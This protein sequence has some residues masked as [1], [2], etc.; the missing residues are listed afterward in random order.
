MTRVTLLCG[1][2]WFALAAGLP[3]QNADFDTLFARLK[4]GP[5]YQTQAPCVREMPTTVKGVPLDNTLQVPENYDPRKKWPLRVQLHGGVSRPAPGR[6][7]KPRGLTTNRIPSDGELI[8][9]PR[10]WDGLEWWRGDQVDNILALVEKV[11]QAFNVDESRI[12]AT[13]I[14]DGGTGV[15]YLAMRVPTLWSACM[16]LNGQPLV[17]AN[18]DV[19]AEGELFATN[20]ANCPMYLV[21]GGR[22]PLYPAA[23]V[24]PLVDMMRQAGTAVTFHV[25]PEAGHDT[26]WW[27]RERDSYG[28]FVRTHPRVAHPPR[29]SW[30][31]ARTDRDNRVR[32]LV[33][34]ALG[35]RPSEGPLEEL[36]T[37]ENVAGSPMPLFTHKK[38]SGRVDVQRRGNL[39]LAMTRG[40]REFT[41]LLSP[42]VIDFG[43]PVTVNVNGQVVFEGPVKQDVAVLQKW[44]AR[45]HDRTMLYGAEVKVAVP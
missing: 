30:E 14:S 33:I 37:F 38:S 21:N 17:L 43:K 15:Y 8:L 20:L 12:Y 2:L 27:P 19:G 31:T 41:L 42:D 18:P 40:V 39:I 26:S 9:Q 34:D 1:A 6:G 23:Q 11:K 25:Y 36:N 28:T 22:D 10:A 32:W 13:G 44:A 7:E 24:A 4:E 35:K 45:D 29:L 3:A 5:T 16:P